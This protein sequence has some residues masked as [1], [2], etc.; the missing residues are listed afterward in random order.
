VL[1]PGHAWEKFRSG[2]IEGPNL[3]LPVGRAA[4]LSGETER[5]HAA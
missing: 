4:A 2:A 5:P 3:T 1:P